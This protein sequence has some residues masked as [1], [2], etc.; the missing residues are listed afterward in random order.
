MDSNLIKPVSGPEVPIVDRVVKQIVDGLDNNVALDVLFTLVIQMAKDLRQQ[1]LISCDK[2]VEYFEDEACSQYAQLRV[3][4]HI[5]HRKT[6]R[7]LLLGTMPYDLYDKDSENWKN[8][9]EAGGAGCYL[10]GLSIEGRRGAFLNKNEV[11]QVIGLLQK[12]KAGCVVW[13]QNSDDWAHSQLLNQDRECLETALAIDNYV[14]AER[15][16]WE[17]NQP[18]IQPKLMS[19]GGSTTNIDALTDM[20][21]RRCRVGID[22]GTYQ[23]SSPV[24]I[25]CIQKVPTR[26]IE[27]NPDF[28]TAGK[29][30]KVLKLLVGCIRHMRL[31]PNVHTIP[32]VMVWEANQIALAEILV[33][34]LA[35]S[36]I[37]L[38]GL[39]VVRPG[40]SSPGDGTSVLYEDMR[41]HVWVKR[42]WF[43]EN[44]NLSL[45]ARHNRDILEDALAS[46]HNQLSK[47]DAENL[48]EDNRRIERRLEEKNKEFQSAKEHAEAKH[49]EWAEKLHEVESFLQ[50]SSGLFPDSSSDAEGQED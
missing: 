50:L 33:T 49:T 43:G 18:Y 15:E 32:V 22:P 10:V 29:S 26:I 1:R 35:Q 21:R 7:S 44:I 14:V 3:L 36:L 19:E 38:N 24:Y 31:R 17:P 11:E 8:V 40:T 23:I 46:I 47:G 9:Y 45:A 34:I 5:I 2:I 28:C 39:N 30:S 27:H 6:L 41:K 25:G 13:N 4:F 48:I 20:L 16:K 37:S 42:S 12:Y